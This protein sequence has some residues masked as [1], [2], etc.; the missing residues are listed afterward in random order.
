MPLAWFHCNLARDKFLTLFINRAIHACKRVDIKAFL[1]ENF[2]FV[3]TLLDSHYELLLTLVDECY[4]Q[5]VRMFYA[6]IQTTKMGVE[7]SLECQ[8]KYIKFTLTESTH[9]QT[10]GLPTVTSQ[11]L[12]K[13]KTKNQ[14]LVEFAYPPCH[15]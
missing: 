11:N 1:A 7:I 14:C 12:S 10:L 4:P 8:V 2:S 5:L 6:N 13:S 9:N 15:G 3:N